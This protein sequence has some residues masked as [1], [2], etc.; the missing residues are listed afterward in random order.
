VRAGGVY[1]FF[2][3]LAPD[4][5]FFHTV[6]GRVAQLELQALGGALHPACWRMM[7]VGQA[8]FRR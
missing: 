8:A 6:E 1:S 2:N 7:R 4:N 3:G 5:I